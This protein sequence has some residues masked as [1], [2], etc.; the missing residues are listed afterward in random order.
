MSG[1]GDYAG[2]D[3]ISKAV[4]TRRDHKM[5]EVLNQPVASPTVLLN[6]AFLCQILVDLFGGDEISKS[7]HE[8]HH[9]TEVGFAESGDT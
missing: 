1:F 6:P 8:N 7:I 9:R 4:H 2:G 3:I 5:I